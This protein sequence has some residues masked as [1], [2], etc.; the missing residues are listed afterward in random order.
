M[1]SELK[2]NLT[3]LCK[4][5]GEHK[6]LPIVM[7]CLEKECARKRMCCL[8]CVDDLHCKHELISVKKFENYILSTLNHN[9]SMKNR[10]EMLGLL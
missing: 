8:T 10:E 1:D 3:E 9:S 6:N 2:N 5:G 7:I 4:K